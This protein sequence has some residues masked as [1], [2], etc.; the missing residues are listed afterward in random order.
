[1]MCDGLS[2]VCLALIVERVEEDRGH[3]DPHLLTGLRHRVERQQPVLAIEHAQHTV[4]LG[5]LEQAEIVVTGDRREGEPLLGGDDHGAGDR[6][7]RARVLALA[8]VRGELVDLAPDDRTLVRGF[9]LADA[10]LEAV[11]VDPR[12]PR[13]PPLRLL[14]L[15][16]TGIAEDL[17]LYQPVDVL[18]GKPRLIELDTELLD[19]PCGYRDHRADTLTDPQT[20]VNRGIFSDERLPPT[21]RRR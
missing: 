19:A 4:L 21:R 1:M 3:L 2:R 17:E 9:A 18:R 8:I 11:P 10:P 7:Q 6:G 20:P 5:D 15:G 13:R 12:P 14:D 16:P